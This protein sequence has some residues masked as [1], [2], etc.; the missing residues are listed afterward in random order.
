LS[1]GL[2]GARAQECDCARVGLLSQYAT[3]RRYNICVFSGF[4]TFFEIIL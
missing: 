3:H 2:V 1:G 4:T